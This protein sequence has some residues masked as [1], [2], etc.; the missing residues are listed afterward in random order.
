MLSDELKRLR[1][2]AGI[3]QVALAERTGV[4]LGTIRNIETGRVRSPD[5]GTLR[6]IGH[7]LGITG[8]QWVGI[9]RLGGEG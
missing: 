6:A 1:T 2:E 7:A 9:L 5:L 8:D 4:A 3:S